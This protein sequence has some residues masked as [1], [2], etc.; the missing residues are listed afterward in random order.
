MSVTDL[1]ADQLT[2]IRN[3]IRIGKKTVIIKKSGIIEGI[4]DII[5]REGFIDN[6]KVI[7]D[8]KQGQIKIYLKYLDDGTPV[9]EELKRISKSGRRE[10]IGT[11]KIKSVMGGVGIAILSTSKGLL[12]DKEAKEQ[13][14]GGEL[15]CQV[16]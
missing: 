5:K 13:Q 16:W 15:V 11:K 1:I 8:D 10:Y 9:M 4:V 6:Y 2:V 12:T 3:A 7:E 14:I